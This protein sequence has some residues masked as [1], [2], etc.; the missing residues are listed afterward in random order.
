MKQFMIALL[1]SLSLSA[2]SSVY[3]EEQVFEN[4]FAVIWSFTSLDRD[5]INNNV[6]EQAAQTIDLWKQGIIENVYMDPEAKSVSEEQ[7][8]RI[9]FFIK[10]DTR[11]DAQTI[12]D[13]MVFVQKKIAE[14]NLFKVGFLW[15]KAGESEPEEKQ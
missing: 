11:K 7:I 1:L 8:T 2:F 13:D 12:L 6:A 5:L 14:Y 4:N 15:L 9:T 3:A 10:A